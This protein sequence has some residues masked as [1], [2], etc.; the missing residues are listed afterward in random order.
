MSIVSLG[1][2]GVQSNKTDDWSQ[3]AQKILGFQQ[4][5]RG[6]KTLSFRMDDYKQRFVVSD[7]LGDSPIVIGWEVGGKAALSTFADKIEDAGYK[8]QLGTNEL[9]TQRCVDSL[10]VFNDPDGNRIEMFANPQIT[11]EPFIPGRP[12]SGFKTGALGMGHAV[13]HV[14]DTEKLVPFYQHEKA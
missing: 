12:I 7:E 9:A 6:A 11:T 8:V 13:L 1:Y 3:F 4:I 14:R 2:L 5:D 10:I